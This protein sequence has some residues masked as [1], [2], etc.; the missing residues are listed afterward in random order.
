MTLS[1][2]QRQKKLEKK[3]MK[4]QLVKRTGS[5]AF[6]GTGKA[7]NYAKYPIY[8]CLVPSELFETGLGTI[9]VTRRPPSGEIAIT[10]FVVDVF[11]LG[12]KNVLF[13]LA[14]EQDYH[15]TVKPRLVETHE[16]QQFEN[17]HPSCVRKIIEGAVDYAGALGF[18]YHT[19]YKNA[20]DIF[21]DIDASACPVKYEFG[22]EGKPVYIRGPNES[23]SQA[24]KIVAQLDRRCGE[25]NFHYLVSLDNGIYE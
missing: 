15:N 9:I 22:Q 12:V 20:R 17:T 2:R 21:G 5:T 13:K 18:S 24:E 3:K 23:V 1:A 7:A 6:A 16:G 11:C 4:R 8:E 19:D 14:S 10:A 25:G